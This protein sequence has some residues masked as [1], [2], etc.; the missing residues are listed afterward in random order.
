MKSVK[1]LVLGA[2][3]VSPFIL[4]QSVAAVEAEPTPDPSRT[5]G[6]IVNFTGND[7]PVNPVDP[8]D[9]GTDIQPAN[10][11]G[12]APEVGTSGPLSLD[13]ASTISFGTNKIST[14]DQ[15]Y[16]ALA[17]MGR[18]VDEYRYLPNYVQVT[19]TRG[20]LKGWTLSVKQNGQFKSV[21]SNKVLTGAEIT[22]SSGQTASISESPAPTATG[23]FSLNP[24][25]TGVVEN[26]MK[27][28]EGQG[29]GTWV[30]RFGN[31]SNVIEVPHPEI[32]SL[33]VETNTVRLSVPGST[34]KV[35]EEYKTS[36]TWTLSNLPVNE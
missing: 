25:G 18:A 26:V 29:A 20:T 31:A 15:V 10:P 13:F 19:D 7:G 3:A 21:T 28:A 2:L 23:T 6:A 1:H 22:F 8:L 12:S 33:T 32:P 9:P 24:D 35:S 17:Q 14:K 11:D 36:L 4:S 34:N 30:Y 16:N 27:A 5:T